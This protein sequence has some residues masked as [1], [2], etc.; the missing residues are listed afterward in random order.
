MNQL[1]RL[2][3]TLSL[4]QKILTGIAAIAVAGAIAGLTRWQSERDYVVLYQGLASEDAAA[5]AARLKESGAEYRL[6]AGG[7]T[8]RVRTASADE[9]RL[10]LAASGIPKTGRIGFE[11]FDQNNFGR[12]EFTEKINFNRALEGELERTVKT[13][14]EVETARIHLTVPKDSVFLNERRPAKAS[15]LVGLRPG[16]QLSPP[17]VK[18]ITHLVSSAVEG[19]TP[20]MISILDVHGNLLTKPKSSDAGTDSSLNDSLLEYKS[21]IE[22]DLLAKVN[23]TLEPLLGPERFRAAVSADCDLTTTD[24]SEES[25]DPS[26]SVMTS[27]Q[28]TEDMAGTPQPSGIPGTASNLPR[29][30]SRPASASQTVARR[31]ENIAYQS[32]RQIRR[33]HVPQGVIKRLS[34]SVLVDHN[35][36]F[37][38][39]GAKQQRI[40]EAPSPER[41]KAT[42]DLVAAAVG[43]LPDRGDQLI[44]ETLPFSSTLSYEPPPATP[45]G[46][47]VA[48]P[49]AAP[50]SN[51]IEPL[52]RN[53][54]HFVLIGGGGFLLVLLGGMYLFFRKAQHRKQRVTVEA[55]DPD[56]ELP[57]AVKPSLPAPEAEG[58]DVEHQLQAERAKQQRR[59][60]LQEQEILSELTASTKLP[61]N[62]TKKTEVLM[63]HLAEETKRNPDTLTQLVR[64]WL[65]DSEA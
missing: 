9:L 25:Y 62:S 12:T 53:N 26:R 44:V 23:S 40:V 38:G 34:V 27:S 20:D 1:K 57:P 32:T 64:S 56:A 14:K 4:R 37:E 30:T 19:L 36:R 10:Q 8:I 45:S 11:I 33:T 49:P 59:R 22:R 58:A 17:N 21:K 16:M 54:R 48:G 31:S 50:V 13:I 63:K 61:S 47:P 35:V 60:T 29:P 55:I 6:E 24:Q 3:A 5:V 15:V 28:R 46:A 39:A 65:V 51:V 43:L 18:A 41:M 7:S 2:F 42:R 52:W